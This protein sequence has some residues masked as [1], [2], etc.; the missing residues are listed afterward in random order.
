MNQWVKQWVE[1]PTQVV[2]AVDAH[3]CLWV[4]GQL[5]SSFFGFAHHLGQLAE[6]QNGLELDAIAH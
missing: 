1:V 6:T 4:D 3:Q 5:Q 2:S